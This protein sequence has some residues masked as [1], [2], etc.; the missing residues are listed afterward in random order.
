MTKHI[1]ALTFLGMLLVAGFSHAAP[2]GEPV[3]AQSSSDHVSAVLPASITAPMGREIS[4]QNPT[5]IAKSGCSAT[6]DCPSGSGSTPL[7]CTGNGTCTTSPFQVTCD[8][9]T[10]SCPCYGSP[11]DPYCD[12]QCYIDFGG[13][14]A[15]GR[16]VKSCSFC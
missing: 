14:L 5:P 15:A 10:H 8:G 13:T 11:C 3:C 2:L 7:T 1:T 6:T 16:C 4:G 9:V 12:C